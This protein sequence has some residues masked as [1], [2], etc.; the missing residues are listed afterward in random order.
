MKQ[1]KLSP[2]AARWVAFVER[3]RDVFEKIARVEKRKKGQGKPSS[4][5]RYR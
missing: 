5:A 2:S 3:N 4:A 1:Q